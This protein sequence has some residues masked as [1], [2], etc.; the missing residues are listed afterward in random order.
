LALGGVTAAAFTP[1][2]GQSKFGLKGYLRTNWS[3][4]PFSLGSYSYIAKASRQ[5]DTA[6]LAAPIDNRIFFAGEATHPRANSTVHAAYETGLDAA[7]SVADTGAQRVIVVGAGMSG[8]AAA[9]R[10]SRAGR[11]VVVLEARRRIGGRIWTNS[12]LG[13]PLDLGAS[14]IHGPRGNPLTKLANSVG[15]SRKS[16]GDSYTYRNGRGLEMRE[17]DT[18]DWIDDVTEFEHSFGT[19]RSKVNLRAAWAQPSYGG[20]DVAFPKG[21]AQLFSGLRG[22]YETRLG[23]IVDKVSLTG[24]GV[25]VGLSNA[26][27]VAADAVIVTLPLGVLKTGRVRFEPSLPQAKAQAIKRLGFGVLDK[28]YLKY[29]RVFWDKNTSWIITPDN[30]LPKGQFNQW[31]NLSPFLGQPIIMAFNAGDVARSLG[32]LSDAAILNRGRRAIESA[33][34]G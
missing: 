30:G 1:A 32:T 28:L 5:S 26:S 21:Y 3:R 27:T 33:Y 25:T 11:D 23:A 17:R 24:Q 13:V 7:Q 2:V 20:A 31:L 14:W 8:L 4:D 15:A 19:E 9:A 10:L 29:D 22:N 34:T 12:S 18:P 16:T 6:T